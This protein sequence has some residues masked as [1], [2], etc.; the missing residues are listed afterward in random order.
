MST[1]PR[2]RP[3]VPADLPAVR[4]VLARALARDPL[5]DWIFGDHP[6]REAAVATF[7][8]A[9][10]ETYTLAGTTWLA[11]DDERAVGAAAWSVP[12]T[13]PVAADGGPATPGRSMLDLLLPAERVASIRSGFEAMSG[14]LP[15]E[16]HALLHLLGVDADQ[17]GRGTGAALV[18]AALDTLPAGLPAHV[19]T[20]VDANVRF[21][22]ARGFV[23]V[24]SVR[25]GERGP[26]MHGL[27]HPGRA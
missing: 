8:W 4:S 9:P 5:M 26:V 17:R 3:A 7:L 14:Q 24:G 12:G 13:A 25:L 11:L 19:N 6:H 23:R 10:V 15:D 22:E 27:R 21:Y 1:G 16:P 2:V 18:S 20:T